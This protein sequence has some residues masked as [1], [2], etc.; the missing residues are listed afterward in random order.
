MNSDQ[1][2]AGLEAALRP[3][4]D[5]LQKQ[6][7][8]VAAYA[9]AKRADLARAVAQ[10]GFEEAVQATLDDIFLFA[11]GRAVDMADAIDARTFGVVAG[12]LSVAL[13]AR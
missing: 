3:L 8:E 10:P 13:G 11:A 9:D 6:P 5:M 7:A 12:A 4:G 2:R 1:F